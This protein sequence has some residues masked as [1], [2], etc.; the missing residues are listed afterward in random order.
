APARIKRRWA[1]E[2]GWQPPLRT[3]APVPIPEDMTVEQL[4]ALAELERERTER[5]GPAREPGRGLEREPGRGLERE[6]GRGL[7]WEPGA[8]AS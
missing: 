2:E 8:G 7:E 5:R 1:P 4:L 3:P 6:P